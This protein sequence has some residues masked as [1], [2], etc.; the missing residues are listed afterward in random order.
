MFNLD[1]Q[2]DPSEGLAV[3]IPPALQ[4]IPC[5][6]EKIAVFYFKVLFSGKFPSIWGETCCIVSKYVLPRYKRF[7]VIWINLLYSAKRY[8][9]MDKLPL[10]CIKD[11]MENSLYTE[12]EVLL[13]YFITGE[14]FFHSKDKLVVFY[15]TI[16][17]QSK[18][19][20]M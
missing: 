9:Y 1:Q 15:S 7:M 12:E 13:K 8:Y 17:I 3:F 11:K 19:P 20:N 10:Y 16:V 5:F 4:K 6:K 2:P 14:N 18:I